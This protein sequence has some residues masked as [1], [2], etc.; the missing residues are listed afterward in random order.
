[1]IKVK[2]MSII[3][4]YTINT[5]ILTLSFAF[6]LYSIATHNTIIIISR[7]VPAFIMG[8]PIVYL[9]I[10]SFVRVHRLSKSISDK[11]FSIS[12]FRARKILKT[13]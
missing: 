9:G 5:I 12:N 10:I 4:L 1:M 13:K 7:Q 3:T 6:I 2:K 11:E 8:L